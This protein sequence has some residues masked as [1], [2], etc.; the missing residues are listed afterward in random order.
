[1]KRKCVSTVEVGGKEVKNPVLKFLCI[2]AVIGIIA[3]IFAV[4]SALIIPFL[5][6]AL[7]LI[8]LAGL[9]MI[10]AHPILRFLGFQGFWKKTENA[11]H[12][13]CSLSTKGAF[14]RK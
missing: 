2:V 7:A 11:G 9:G 12:L 8:I 5:I 14:K 1:M 3:V 13:A 10:I 6:V 4:G